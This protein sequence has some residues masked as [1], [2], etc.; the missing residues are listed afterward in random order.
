M[1]PAARG[2][3]TAVCIQWSDFPESPAACP[4]SRFRGVVFLNTAPTR[5]A[6]LRESRAP[7][8]DQ[9]Y[10]GLPRAPTKMQPDP[11]PPPALPRASPREFVHRVNNML[12]V[13]LAHAEATKASSDPDELREAMEII[14]RTAS[15][16]ADVVRD[17]AREYSRQEHAQRVAGR[18]EHK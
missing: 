10:E 12:C 15:S 4:G 3:S 8:E 5:F 14:A 1:P 9:S 2:A 11:N 18:T 16:M 13:V 6:T 17:Y 7:A